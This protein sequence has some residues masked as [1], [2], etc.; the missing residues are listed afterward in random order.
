MHYA[1]W[2][3]VM[4]VV[5]VVVLTDLVIGFRYLAPPDRDVHGIPPAELVLPLL[6]IK[7][8]QAGPCCVHHHLPACLPLHHL[9]Y[10]PMHL[11]T[12]PLSVQAHAFTD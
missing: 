3:P 4:V 9:H 8:P 7:A 6:G 2:H 11:H 1:A 12:E 5:M 10:K